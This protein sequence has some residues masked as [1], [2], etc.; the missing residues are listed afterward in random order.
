MAL[1]LPPELLYETPP[2]GV[3][4]P[5]AP[6][7]LQGAATQ[8]M[9]PGVWA[10]PPPSEDESDTTSTFWP[11]LS[12]AQR[13]ALWQRMTQPFA[14]PP[15]LPGPTTY[16]PPPGAFDIAPSEDEAGTP[17]TALPMPIY[18]PNIAPK[19]PL[20]MPAYAQQPSGFESY[21]FE[22]NVRDVAGLIPGVEQA[23]RFGMGEP[24]IQGEGL[25]RGLD[26]AANVA[27]VAVFAG[28]AAKGVKGAANLLRASE[29]FSRASA[30][31]PRLATSEQGAIDLLSRFFPSV[32]ETTIDSAR[33]VISNL[34]DFGM[35]E[36]ETSLK[37]RAY[38]ALN[39][40]TGTP[41]QR[42]LAASK[43]L[44]ESLPGGAVSLYGDQYSLVRNAA[45]AQGL[46]AVKV[47]GR[48]ISTLQTLFHGTASPEEFASLAT[49]D[50][51]PF[52]MSPSPWYAGGYTGG[53]REF[54]AAAGPPRMFR[55]YLNPQS[56]V[57]DGIDMPP[58][59]QTKTEVELA[60]TERELLQ[61]MQENGIDA[62]RYSQHELAFSNP[63]SVLYD[64]FA[65]PSIS[66]LIKDEGGFVQATG[67]NKS[68]VKSLLK[69]ASLKYEDIRLHA[70]EA[71]VDAIDKTR[72]TARGLSNEALEDVSFRHNYLR[73]VVSV[74]TE[75]SRMVYE[76]EMNIASRAGLH[77]SDIPAFQADVD[78]YLWVQ[79]A[80]T[81]KKLHPKARSRPFGSFTSFTDADAYLAAL[82]NHPN[83]Q[84]IT[85]AAQLFTDNYKRSRLT[86]YRSGLISE[87]EYKFLE[88]NYPNYNPIRYLDVGPTAFEKVEGVGVMQRP[89]KSLAV[90]VPDFATPISPHDQ[91]LLSNAA[92]ERVVAQ[93]LFVRDTLNAARQ[94]PQTASQFRRLRPNQHPRPDERLVTLRQNGKQQTWA[95]PEW[96]A[97][98]IEHKLALPN[99]GFIFKTW[100]RF[101]EAWR[102]GAI[103][104]N[105]NFLRKNLF[106]DFLSSYATTGTLPGAALGDVARY[107]RNEP[108]DELVRI[109][110]LAG[111]EQ[112]RF[113]NAADPEVKVKAAQALWSETQKAAKLNTPEDFTKALLNAIP[114]ML[115]QVPRA[116]AAT[117]QGQR[118]KV[119]EN[120]LDKLRPNWRTMDVWD[121]VDTREARI[122]AN[123]ALESIINYSRGGWLSQ[124]LSQLV[125]FFNTAVQGFYIPFRALSTP[126]GRMRVAKMAATYMG[127][128]W[129][130]NTYP[131]NVDVPA[132][133]R[134]GSFYIMLPSDKYDIRGKKEPK[135]LVIAPM[136]DWV[137]LFSPMAYAVEKFIVD[138]P[139]AGFR[140][141]A[142]LLD[143][144]PTGV[145]LGPVP[146]TAI[147]MF[148]NY[149][150][151]RG[152]PVVAEGE[153]Y[154]TTAGLESLQYGAGTSPTAK[155]LG[156]LLNTS[157]RM[158]E[159]LISEVGAAPGRELLN[160]GDW[161]I[162]TFFAGRREETMRGMINN[163]ME[164]DPSTRES[165]L[166]LLPAETRKEIETQ[167]AL[168]RQTPLPIIGQITKSIAPVRQP[169]T[170]KVFPR[171]YEAR[172]A[173]M[174]TAL[175]YESNETLRVLRKSVPVMNDYVTVEGHT[176]RLDDKQ[177]AN[178]HEAFKY[179]V[180]SELT[181]ILEDP[182]FRVLAY[183]STG[184]QQAKDVVDKYLSKR[185]EQ[186]KMAALTTQQKAL[187]GLPY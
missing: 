98:E 68:A 89:I 170:S 26:I 103:E 81:Y 38:D 66:S 153:Q 71:W 160:T 187:L 136:R 3:T 87:Q 123:T 180:A 82:P 186:I 102:V 162:D 44:S 110:R 138:S 106:V 86:L 29:A 90:D 181:M 73:S 137:P 117:E 12:A 94:N 111:A 27:D 24:A 65:S 134:L 114:R 92:T 1:K 41:E 13:Q 99:H 55:S 185:E 5:P 150:L 77:P 167:Y 182:G 14:P 83:Q 176:A 7:P 50:G 64:E 104:Y 128:T 67:L 101:N 8:V 113:W 159:T 169:E 126:Q 151:N 25:G 70:A 10:A 52:W 131:E 119:F 100:H 161:I 91:L 105:L 135:Y 75:R 97:R 163:I 179:L 130:N 148:A 74:A 39:A 78:K 42:L 2:V 115:K 108:G 112:A 107:F 54:A 59:F 63:E 58:G 45:R 88:L 96:F 57:V 56:R 43:T 33:R 16:Y 6:S 22:R 140:I 47:E 17:F 93:N 48:V 122:A 21:L 142:Q 121:V 147:A 124:E 174:A 157:P 72:D 154:L 139:T 155:A 129:Y 34:P 116:G 37:S 40:A 177:L 49:K 28:L 36:L 144:L 109:F 165:V 118:L 133:V 32:S 4:T 19:Q 125:P 51:R 145:G 11:S 171:S 158:L 166:T 141:G 156:K 127:V 20:D 53:R 80:A 15:P 173:D 31:I 85:D 175:G 120:A 35:P 18:Y 46:P 23:V 164:L 9:G 146:N 95:A 152:Q 69:S 132:D 79:T 172:Q 168:R 178:A 149:N 184:W 30:S 183:S 76:G 62:V 143:N 61:Y 60:G 84:A